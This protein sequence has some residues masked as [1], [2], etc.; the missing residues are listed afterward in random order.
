MEKKRAA[1][2][3]TAPEGRLRAR[4]EEISKAIGSS[5][6]AI[7]LPEGTPIRKEQIEKPSEGAEVFVFVSSEAVL[8]PGWLEG[9]VEALRP[10]RVFLQGDASPE[11]ASCPS[12][13]YG[14]IG[15][16]G[17]VSESTKSLAQKVSLSEEDLA[18]GFEGYAARRRE[19]LSGRVSSAETV[20]AFLFAMSRRCLLRVLESGEPLLRPF[21]EWSGADLALRVDRCGFRVA[22][23]ESV[24]VSRTRLVESGFSEVGSIEDR[25]AF[26][27]AHPASGSRIAAAYRIRISTLRDLSVLRVSLARVAGLVDGVA[28]LL[29]TNPL[30]VQSDPNFER[31]VERGALPESDALLLQS[32]SG[33]TPSRVANAFGEWVARI[34]RDRG[35]KASVTAEVWQDLPN[36]QGERNSV[37]RL[38]RG[39]GASWILTLDH[40]EVVEDRIDRALLDRFVSHPNP[41]VRAFD[42]S[43]VFHF[44]SASLV[45]EDAPFGD[46]GTYSGGPHSIRLWRLPRSES[47]EALRLVEE[48]SSQVAPEVGPEGWRVASLRLRSFAYLT[49]GDRERL[50]PSSGEGLRCSTFQSRNGI[51]LH[52]LVYEREEPE[53][54]ARWLDVVHAIFDRVVLVWTSSSEEPSEALRKVAWLHGAEIVEHPLDEDLAGARNAGIEALASSRSLGS[55]MFVDPDEWLADEVRDP[56]ALRRMAESDRFGWLVQVANY[57]NDGDVP[58][59]SDSVRVSRLDDSASMR[60]S[61]RVHE[62]FSRSTHALQEKGIHPRLRY[63]PFVLQH[64]GMSFDAARMGEKLDH[65]E[66]LLR[67][68]LADDPRNPGAWVSL[69]WHYA[70][71]GES[72]LAEECYRRG[73]SCSGLSYLP[74]KELGFVRLREARALFE[75]SLDR[76][77]DSHQFYPTCKRIVDFLRVNAPPHSVIPRTGRTVLDLPDFPTSD[78][79]AG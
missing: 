63:A 75:Q 69:G 70:N 76:L 56:L 41:L 44:E 25:L 78:D 47:G 19:L 1:V 38:A 34:L 29:L 14:A 31:A 54:V 33:A 66:R 6:V 48:G 9:L 32:C 15:L 40:D 50:G 22:V 4:G 53:D 64:R 51:G 24:F 35:S 45:R 18:A 2:V 36:P 71:D 61:G 42:V 62:G 20:D 17:P 79:E 74:A 67:L 12:G 23:A 57:R 26:Y 55:A 5:D 30:E 60:M 3:F 49:K 68:E 16:V 37:H 58:T 27:E 77:V 21:G 39:L 52:M 8:S 43:S 65:Y 10:E 11:P 13:D 73:L 72:A 7:A 46:G 59:I 28:A